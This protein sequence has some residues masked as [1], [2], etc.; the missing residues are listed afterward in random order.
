MM[1]LAAIVL[2]KQNKKKMDQ[3]MR[4]TGQMKTALKKENEKVQLKLNCSNRS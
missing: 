4:L 1:I 2:W 3:K